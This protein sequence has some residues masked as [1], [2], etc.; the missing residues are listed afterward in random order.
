MPL[1][2]TGTW[3]PTG[4]MLLTVGGTWF[5]WQKTKLMVNYSL[6][7]REGEG[8]TNQLFAIQFQAGF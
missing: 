8:T 3:R 2:P 4:T 7:R 6:T 5:I 1:T